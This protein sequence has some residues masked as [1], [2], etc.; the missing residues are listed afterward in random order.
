MEHWI[1]V[2]RGPC[3]PLCQINAGRHYVHCTGLRFGSRC[4]IVSSCVRISGSNYTCFRSCCS[5]LSD[6]VIDEM[7]AVGGVLIIGIGLSMLKIRDFNIGNL[8][9]AILIPHFI[10]FNSMDGK[11]AGIVVLTRFIPFITLS[12]NI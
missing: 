8:L 6:M 5:F 2:L 9:P 4:F 10:F 11:I 3:N 7:T 1:Q 12:D